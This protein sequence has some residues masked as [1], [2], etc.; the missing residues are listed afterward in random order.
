MS[1]LVNV[2]VVGGDWRTSDWTA[3]KWRTR[4]ADVKKRWQAPE[5]AGN[6]QMRG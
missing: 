2:V 5:A 6:R 1:F 3:N 4:G